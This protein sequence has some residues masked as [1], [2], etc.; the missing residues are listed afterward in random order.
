[1]VRRPLLALIAS[2]ALLVP[3]TLLGG[4]HRVIATDGSQ[5]VGAPSPEIGAGAPEVL[6]EWVLRPEDFFACETA[7][8]DLRR[9]RREYGARVRIATYL[10]G[11]DTALARSFLRKERLGAVELTAISTADFARNYA[12]RFPQP[13]TTPL[14]VLVS[15]GSADVA[16]NADVRLAAG[17]RGVVELGRRL[18]ALLQPDRPQFRSRSAAMEGGEL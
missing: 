9:A 7:A 18:D 5:H 11:A 2:S 13:V 1:M 16:F 15:R 3:S 4:V 17:R 6:I 14:A 8:P 12:H 10:V